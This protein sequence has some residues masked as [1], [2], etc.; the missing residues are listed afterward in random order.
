[1]VQTETSGIQLESMKLAFELSIV[2]GAVLGWIRDYAENNA[3]PVSS[4]SA[5]RHLYTVQTDERHIFSHGHLLFDDTTRT[6]GELPNSH[7][8]V[9]RQHLK[10]EY[11]QETFSRST[12]HT[13][14]SVRP[15]KGPEFQPGVSL[16]V[17]HFYLLN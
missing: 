9:T 12:V 5:S 17:S 11:V 13:C 4:S 6:S 1:M 8:K 3:W 10:L 16:F 14:T 7:M 15:S 2:L